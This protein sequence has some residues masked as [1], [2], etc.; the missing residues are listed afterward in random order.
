[1]SQ[2]QRRRRNP[3]A[4]QN[5]LTHGLVALQNKIYRRTRRGHKFDAGCEALSLSPRNS[6]FFACCFCFELARRLVS[7]IVDT[8]SIGAVDNC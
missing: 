3:R 5:H 7:T 4:T 8:N 1:M 6:A 2:T